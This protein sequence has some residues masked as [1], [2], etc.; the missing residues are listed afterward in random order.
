[1]QAWSEARVELARRL[2]FDGMHAPKRAFDIC[3]LWTKT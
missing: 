1:L 3:E 2:Q